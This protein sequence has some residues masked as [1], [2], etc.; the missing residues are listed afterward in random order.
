MGGGGGNVNTE[1]VSLA[2]IKYNQIGGTA[3]AMDSN[4]V[5]VY[6]RV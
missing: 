6:M 4:G 1:E 5:R 3:I 2:A